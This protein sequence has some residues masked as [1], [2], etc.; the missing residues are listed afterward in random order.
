MISHLKP[1]WNRLVSSP[2][3][4]ATPAILLGLLIS[5]LFLL[6]SID[7]HFDPRKYNRLIF[8]YCIILSVLLCKNK[9]PNSYINYKIFNSI[10]ISFAGITL[11]CLIFHYIQIT[12]AF[13]NSFFLGERDFTSMAEVILNTSKGLW[14]YSP[15]HGEE[16]DSY[17]AHHFAPLLLLF[18]PFT[19]LSET[20]L[21]LAWG[22]L[23]YFVTLLYII[24]NIIANLEFKREFSSSDSALNTN[25]LTY[26]YSNE[27]LEKFLLF[28]F[29]LSNIYLYR[30][31]TSYHFEILFVIFFLLLIHSLESKTSFIQILFWTICTIFVKED[32]S[33]YL[34]IYFLGNTIWIYGKRIKSKFKNLRRNKIN[35]KLPTKS[36]SEIES[37]AF[38]DGNFIF[39]GKLSYLS[40]N[41][42]LLSISVFTFTVVLPLLR[43]ILDVEAEE[44]WWQ[45]WS[46][47]GTSTAGIV[48][49]ILSDLPRAFNEVSKHSSTVIEIALSTGLLILVK[50]RYWFYILCLFGI[51]FLSSRLWHNSF[52]N[53]YIYPL[54]PILLYSTLEGWRTLRKKVSSSLRISV[55]LIILGI[56]FYRNSWDNNFPFALPNSK[57]ARV[58]LAESMAAKI[59]KNSQVAV[60]FD[61]GIFLS[62][63]SQIFPLE[64]VSLESTSRNRYSKELETNKKNKTK[65]EEQKDNYKNKF[66][67]GPLNKNSKR[68]SPNIN[69]IWIDTKQGFS[70]YV[71]LSQ[72]D[73]WKEIW[74]SNGYEIFAEENGMQV[75]RKLD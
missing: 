50:P 1:A 55:L 13:R 42:I 7:P 11:A 2:N 4:V 10:L 17:L 75:L 63:S 28:L 3:F 14:F 34:I 61:L 24:W 15:F 45:I 21:F 22:Q 66:K 47:W 51:H 46:T 29:L 5:F 62:N 70:P 20:R 23:F 25:S 59:P 18:V 57:L 37:E 58:E 54:L 43:K 32:A 53:Y 67:H 48:I 8:W 33:I 65:Q 56:S 52:Y 30:I 41:L 27:Y 12:F 39:A 36:S 31:L 71:S 38:R 60:Q 26:T 19:F 6:P 64:A 35:T 68:I 74:L 72:I 16:S 9:N 40:R 73:S 49:G 44:N 69:Y